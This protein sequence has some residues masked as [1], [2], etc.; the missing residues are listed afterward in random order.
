VS[1]TG[2]VTKSGRYVR[3][4]RTVFVTVFITCT[5]TATSAS[6]AGTTY[7][8]LPIAASQNDCLTIANNT[9]NI[10]LGSGVLDATNDRGYPCSWTATGNSI[11]ISGKY[12]V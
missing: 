8:N 11:T 2:A 9:T 3:I 6:T 5:G 7:F 4:G 12:E 1:G 10:G